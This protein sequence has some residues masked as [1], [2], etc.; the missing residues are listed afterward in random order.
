MRVGISWDSNVT[1]V[2]DE[3]SSEPLTGTL[4][5]RKHASW[6]EL[7]G[8]RLDYTFYRTDRWEASAGYSFFG[9]YVNEL[10]SFNVMDH[11]ANVTLLHRTAVGALPVQL[12]LQY[13]FDDLFLGEKEFVKRHTVTL[14]ATVVE[15]ERHLTQ[16]FFRLQGK[17]FADVSS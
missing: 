16:G 6:V 9:T 3:N 2:P 15:S 8:L 10:P 4:R 1:V 7:F 17:D 5:S 13:A 11:L 14:S 12:G